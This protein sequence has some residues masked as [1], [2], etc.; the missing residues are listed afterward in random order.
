MSYEW[1]QHFMCCLRGLSWLF[2]SERL[3]LLVVGKG[4][5]GFRVV[6]EWRVWP[7]GCVM[8]SLR[9]ACAAASAAGGL[10]AHSGLIVAV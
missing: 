4:L 10:F 1:V 8:A 3:L 2:D 9:V 7:K 6:E 5:I